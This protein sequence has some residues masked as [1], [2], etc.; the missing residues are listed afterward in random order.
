M[1]VRGLSPKL[2]LTL[3]SSDGY[4]LNKTHKEMI[5]QNLKMLLLTSPGERI[6]E[7]AF[8]AGLRS[9]LFEQGGTTTH[10]AIEEN[11]NEQLNLY[12]PYVEIVELTFND[13]DTNS[14]IDANYLHIKM[15]YYIKPL[16][17]LDVIDLDFD[18]SKQ[19]F[20]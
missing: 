14:E 12:M 20:I 7:P 5:K 16:E 13:E 9:F 15:E 6:M 19:L 4:A 17:D 11:I 10:D 8:G 18:F 1:K 3:D 2:P